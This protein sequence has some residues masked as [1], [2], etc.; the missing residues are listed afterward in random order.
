MI[1]IRLMRMDGEHVLPAQTVERSSRQL[2][3]RTKRFLWSFQLVF[4]FPVNKTYFKKQVKTTTSNRLHAGYKILY[5]LA[6]VI[7]RIFE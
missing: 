6:Y 1:Q 2:H 5:T 3:R 4:S 7:I